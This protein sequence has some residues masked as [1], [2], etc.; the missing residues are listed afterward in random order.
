MSLEFCQNPAGCFVVY[1]WV[2]VH[3]HGGADVLRIQQKMIFKCGLKVPT[4]GHIDLYEV[5]TFLVKKKICDAS[6]LDVLP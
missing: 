4:V 5:Q 2:A 3:F 6:L 1:F